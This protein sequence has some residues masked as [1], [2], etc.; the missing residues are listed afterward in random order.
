M[1]HSFSYRLDLVVRL[2]DT[3]IGAPV[4]K[5]QAVFWENGRKLSF[6]SRGAGIYVLVNA[7]RKNR[8]LTVAVRGYLET[9]VD[10]RY[11]ELTENCPEVYVELIPERR[12][13]GE[14]DFVDIRGR[15]P[16]ISSV[17]AVC[18][19]DPLGK[20]ISYSEKN[21]RMKLLAARKLDGK[22]YALIHAQT[23]SFE[24]FQA[25][26]MKNKLVLRLAHPLETEF[27]PEEEISRIVRGR[28]WEDGN[29]LLRLREDGQRM[30]YLIRYVI[31]GKTTFKKIATDCAH[32]TQT[33]SCAKNVRGNED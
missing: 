9:T 5:Q 33:C 22:A 20:V 12:R 10:I 25:E 32:L 23:E 31:K 17:A 8:Q 30:H 3:V 15:I 18:L 13:Y 21:R 14:F 28:V 27:M 19:T 7:G 26:S 29:Y 1:E 16:G 11:E 24:E 6:L 2:V 4:A